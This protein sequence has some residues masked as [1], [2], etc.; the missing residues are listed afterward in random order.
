MTPA[1]EPF[2]T[3]AP[4]PITR[5]LSVDTA[6]LA[7]LIQNSSNSIFLS[8]SNQTGNVNVVM[9]PDANAYG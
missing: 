7:S 6:A 3:P 8:P 4:G 1:P 2:P 5:S 9:A